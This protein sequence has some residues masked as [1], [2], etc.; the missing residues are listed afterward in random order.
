MKKIMMVSLLAALI[1]AGSSFAQQGGKNAAIQATSPQLVNAVRPEPVEYSPH[2]LIEG[3]VTLEIR[4]A[5]DGTVK[6][7]NVLYRT[8][9]MAVSSAIQA[10]EQWKF[11]PATVKGKPVE[12]VVVYSLPFGNNLP[13]FANEDH[14]VKLQLAD[15]EGNMKEEIL[16]TVK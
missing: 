14:P 8:S 4:V 6:G 15:A 3:Y 7:A 13:V 2:R 11:E 16:Y 9:P 10:V 12:A 5:V 1:L